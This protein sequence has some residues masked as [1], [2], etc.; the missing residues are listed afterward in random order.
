MGDRVRDRRSW[1]TARTIDARA[2]ALK[3][4]RV[5]DHYSSRQTPAEEIRPWPS[6]WA[7]LI[8][9]FMILIDTTIVSVANPSIQRGLGTSTTGVLWVT[10][11]YL[12]AYAVPLLV[13]GRLGDRF[14]PRRVFLIGL[15]VF[16]LASLWCGLSNLLPGSGITNLIVARAVQGLGAAVMSP[17]PMAVL[18]RTFP[19]ESRGGAMALWGATAG[20]G[21][22]IGPILGG[23][24][25]DWLGWEWI[26]FVNVPIGLVGFLL[27]TRLVP[28]LELHSHHFD[29]L[30]VVISGVAMFLIVF[31]LQEGNS[32]HWNAWVWSGIGAGV[33]VMG[34]FLWWQAV[35]RNE[36]LL[37]LNL[38][39][40]RNFSLANIAIATVGFAVTALFVPLIYYFQL[41][42]DMTPT[43][44]AL[45]TAPS[46]VLGLVLAAPAGRL[47]DRVHPALLAGPGILLMSGGMGLYSAMMSATTEWWW[48]L[49][50]SVVMGAGS[51]FVWGPISTTANRNL[52][53]HQ[54][55]AGAGVYNATRQLGSVIGSAAIAALMAS[56]IGSELSAATGGARGGSAMAGAAAELPAFLKAP[57]TTAMAQTLLLPAV[58][59]L[60]GAICAFAFGKPAFMGSGADGESASQTSRTA[61][62]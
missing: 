21:T 57:F 42:H 30:G 43:Q 18:T 2:S 41:V 33:V 61:S 32:Y 1:E 7:M 12:L 60:I 11:S 13:T 4:C 28:H 27:V 6:L 19:R 37:P 5:P 46:S 10:S 59:V 44:S 15:T 40:D 23:V 62:H 31:S 3:P 45:M 52:P 14:G 49:I 51:A 34:L 55:G 50:P 39:R 25:V 35:N 58:V 38:F 48:L 24:L 16:T 56:R 20:V 17:Q 54:A 47:T 22:L 26:F 29:W 53:L 9:F 36:P 8:G